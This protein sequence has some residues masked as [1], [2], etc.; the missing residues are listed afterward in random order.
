ANVVSTDYELRRISLVGRI[1]S[2]TRVTIAEAKASDDEIKSIGLVYVGTVLAAAIAFIAWMYRAYKNLGPLGATNLDS[3][4][5]WAIGGW[6][7][8]FLNFRRPYQVLSEMWVESEAAGRDGRRFG[9]DLPPLLGVWW[10]VWVVAGF[11]GN[12]IVRANSGNSGDLGS[13]K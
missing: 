9:V 8:P 4:P 10:V 5:G 7:V 11:L 13:I 1:S 6:L 3:S 2:G 12:V